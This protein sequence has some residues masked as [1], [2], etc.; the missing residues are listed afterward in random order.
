MLAA[1]RAIVRKQM[2]QMPAASSAANFGAVHTMAGVIS[3]FHRPAVGRGG[4]ARPAS[5]TGDIR[6]VFGVAFEQYATAIGAGIFASGAVV[7]QS[8]ATRRFGTFF[9]QYGTLLVSKVWVTR[10]GQFIS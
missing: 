1:G 10:L 9:K 2:P 7:K 6:L 3:Q 8:T 5:Q 4:K